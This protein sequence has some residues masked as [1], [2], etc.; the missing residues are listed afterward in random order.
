MSEEESF[1]PDWDKIKTVS[2]KMEKIIDEGIQ[3][4]MNFIEL[5]FSLYLVKEKINQEKYRVLNK[6][7]ESEDKETHN[8]Y[9]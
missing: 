9:G 3:D 8:M 7:E 1:K 4:K 2:D 5:D 6:V